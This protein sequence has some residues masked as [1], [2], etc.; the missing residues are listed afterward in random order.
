MADV[1]AEEWAS[2]GLNVPAP[3]YSTGVYLSGGAVPT[4]EECLLYQQLVERPAVLVRDALEMASENKMRRMP[5]DKTKLHYIRRFV[6]PRRH[7]RRGCRPCKAECVPDWTLSAPESCAPVHPLSPSLL[8]LSTTTT[9]SRL[10]RGPKMNPVDMG[11]A[12]VARYEQAA[13]IRVRRLAPCS[14]RPCLWR[15]VSAFS[16]RA[17]SS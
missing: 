5:T 1:P 12:R 16:H 3:G 17:P 11:I 4:K 13:G 6:P 8:P 9:T 2:A 14:R 7:G 10:T 15:R